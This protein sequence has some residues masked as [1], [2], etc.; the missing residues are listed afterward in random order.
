MTLLKPVTLDFLTGK[1]TDQFVPFLE[2]Y[3]VHKD[4][5]QNLSK[6]FEAA[7]ESGIDLALTSSFRSFDLQQKIWN[8]KV[9][10]L[11]PVLD[12]DSRPVDI[13]TVTSL[14]LLFL[15]MRWSAIPGGSRHHWGTDIDVYD[16]KTKPADYTVQLIPSEYEAGGY[17]HN[18]AVWLEKNMEQFGFYRPYAQDR[19]GIAPEPWH[20][21]YKP[22]SEK[23]LESF[24]REAFALHL[25][26]SSFRLIEEARAN[27]DELYQR[28]ILV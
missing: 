14:E 1:T 8:E 27:Q 3:L 9:T 4:M 20:L 10:G 28:F 12:S 26:K 21:S 18:A 7:K 22:L 11:R 17:F 5:H 6:M 24:T 16:M 2:N 25:E 13:S 19:G 15:I 23:F